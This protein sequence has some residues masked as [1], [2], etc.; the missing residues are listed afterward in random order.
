MTIENRIPELERLMED[1]ALRSHSESVE[2]L[3]TE[4]IQ[5]LREK[6]PFSASGSAFPRPRKNL[7]QFLLESPFAS[8]DLDLERKQDYGRPIEL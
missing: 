5:S 2:E 4:A 6:Q 1:E 7:A 8:S 3:L